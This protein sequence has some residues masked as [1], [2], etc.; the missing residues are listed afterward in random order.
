MSDFRV[1]YGA[2]AALAGDGAVTG[3]GSGTLPA[4][5]GTGAGVHGVVGAA[6]GTLPALEGAAT[7]TSGFV[8]VGAGT[9]PALTG[10]ATGEH[11]APEVEEQPGAIGGNLGYGRDTGRVRPKQL[12]LFTID[13]SLLKRPPVVSGRGRGALPALQGYAHGAR[14]VAGRGRGRAPALRG[15]SRGIV[16]S[17]GQGKGTLPAVVGQSKGWARLPL[18]QEILAILVA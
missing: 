6:T 9:L 12:G 13:P 4:L 17:I 8:G 5:T 10:S 2:A 11:E 14:G 1:Y 16:A 18:A 3:T 7:G 15:K